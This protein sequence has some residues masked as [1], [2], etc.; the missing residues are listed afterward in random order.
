MN[1]GGQSSTGQLI[2]FMIETH[3]AA[4]KLK[5]EAKEKGVNH[6]VLLEEI[7]QR[8]Q[9]EEKAPF[10]TALTKNYYL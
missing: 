2:D 4:G 6:F 3:P 1:E 9:Q 10:L 7:L 5:A 8:L